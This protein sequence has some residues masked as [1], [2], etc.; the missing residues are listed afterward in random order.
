MRWR[1][2]QAVRSR[3]QPSKLQNYDFAFHV[4]YDLNSIGQAGFTQAPP[5]QSGGA[6]IPSPPTYI[7]R[8]TFPTAAAAFDVNLCFNHQQQ[9]SFDHP[10]S[11]SASTSFNFDA[12]NMDLGPS[13]PDFGASGFGSSDPG[14]LFV[15][16]GGEAGGNVQL[17]NFNNN[18][19]DT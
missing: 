3:N 17:W 1:R 15:N 16:D 5:T 6:A 2:C 7:A 9:I 10:H 13:D 11:A 8:P 4:S 19:F 12:M 18:E 14:R